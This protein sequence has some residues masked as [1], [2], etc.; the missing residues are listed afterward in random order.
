MHC[1][2]LLLGVKRTFNLLRRCQHTELDEHS[3]FITP[4]PFFG[5]FFLA[6][7]ALAA[8]LV[9]DSTIRH[10][11]VPIRFLERFGGEP[12]VPFSKFAGKGLELVG[13]LKQI[14]LS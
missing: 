10:G 7:V 9:A 12:S 5:D 11:A 13:Q 6:N 3:K 8:L 1:T 14:R 2:C 4:Y